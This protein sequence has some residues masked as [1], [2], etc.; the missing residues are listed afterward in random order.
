L[1][2]DR[3]SVEAIEVDEEL[4]ARASELIDVHRLRSLDALHLAAASEIRHAELVVA[5][6][7]ADLSRAAADE[8]LT[9]AP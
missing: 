2:V 7:D 3:S 8:G 1:D 4:I 5:T 9:T 6:W